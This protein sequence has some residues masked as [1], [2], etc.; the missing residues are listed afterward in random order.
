MNWRRNAA[1]LAA[2]A[3]LILSGCASYDGRG[4]K[5]G[6]ASADEVRRT[7]GEPA[8]R[9]SEADGGSLWAYPRGPAGYHTFMVRLDA[10]GSLSS[11]EE[12][13][14][15]RGFSRI[16]IGKSN[17]DEVLKLIGP[18]WRETYFGSR[19]EL[20]WD[21]RFLDAWAFSSQFHVVFDDAGVVRMTMQQRDPLGGN[22]K[23]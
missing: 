22:D 1:M 13:L 11:I 2:A 4:L 8:L 6:M 15:E 3:G 19:K 21:Y 9:W 17:K 5:P 7:M 16:R 14:N 23:N 18:P 10:K 20:A 12:V